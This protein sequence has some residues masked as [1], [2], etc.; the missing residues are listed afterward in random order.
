MKEKLYENIKKNL[1]SRGK[2]PLFLAIDGP[3]ASG[4]TTLANEI[5]RDFSCTLIH[6]D[7]FFLPFAQRGGQEEIGSN[8]DKNTLLHQVL[9]P[10]SQGESVIFSPFS[11]QTGAY[12]PE[13]QVD[14]RELVV[15][16]GVYSLLPEFRDFFQIKV[17]LSA[18][19]ETRKERLI[20][21]GSPWDAFEEIWI[22][23]ETLYFQEH[24]VAD[25][26]DFLLET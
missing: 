22:P 20:Q 17:F 3:C 26:C 24:R 1:V 4:K 6:M 7:D 8:I 9:T 18:S 11:C 25:C 10:L 14:G 21:R 19:F 15:L 16:E 12:L 23:R 5:F 2:A 13:V